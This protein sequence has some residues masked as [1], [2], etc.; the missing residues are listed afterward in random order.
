MKLKDYITQKNVVLGNTEEGKAWA[1]K[2][3]HPADPLT[4]V[5][6][7]PDESAVPSVFQNFQMTYNI[8]NPTASTVGVWEFDLYLFPSPVVMG[9]LRTRDSAGAYL[10]SP[11]VNSQ[12]G[13]AADQWYTRQQTFSDTVERYR[14][15]YMGC[16]GHLDA[17]AVTNQGSLVVAQYPQVPIGLTIDTGSA[18]LIRG[19][20]EAW[21]ELPKTW[22]QLIS[23]PNAYVN[24][25]KEG[26]Y[27]PYKLGLTHQTWQN[28]RDLVPFVPYGNAAGWTAAVIAGAL[29]AGAASTTTVSGAYPYGLAGYYNGSTPGQSMIMKRSDF[30]VIHIAARNLHYQSAFQTVI[31]AGYETQVSPASQLSPFARISP[32]HDALAV[33]GYFAVARE[34]KDAYPEE[35]NGLE[36][37]LGVIGNAVGD[38]VS[39][40]VPGGGMIV[41][42]A[43][44]I[45]PKLIGGAPAD[46]TQMSASQKEK[47]R[48]AVAAAST[49]ASTV[50]KARK[51]IASKKK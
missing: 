48:E 20:L 11:I 47:A 8:T 23:M 4:E 16:T 34:F 44:A 13:L 6:G 19:T 10:W 38:V 15:A 29:P 21:N 9:A 7:I 5:R 35:Y 33:D 41:K 27:A 1:L 49:S 50:S 45:L 31:R 17:A 39:S 22:D 3:L 43:K 26:F 2:A 46:V 28:A 32:R 24:S 51:R 18:Q 42:A 30:G 12:I 25:A 14:I 40:V 37:I 36:E